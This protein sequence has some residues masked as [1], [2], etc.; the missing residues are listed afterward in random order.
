M[1]Y[2]EVEISVGAWSNPIKP[3]GLSDK[4]EYAPTENIT[5]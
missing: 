3:D 4:F 1:R 5:S 2:Y